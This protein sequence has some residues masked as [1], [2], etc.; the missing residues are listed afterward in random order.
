[1]DSLHRVKDYMLRIKAMNSF[2]GSLLWAHQKAS[3]CISQHALWHV[4]LWLRIVRVSSS[5]FC[6]VCLFFFRHYSDKNLHR[7]WMTKIN[8]SRTL[9]CQICNLKYVSKSP[10][11][12]LVF[13]SVCCWCWESSSFPHWTTDPQVDLAKPPGLL[14]PNTTGPK[15]EN[16][17]S[18][19]YAMCAESVT[20]LTYNKYNNLK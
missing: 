8:A 4:G 10:K 19:L 20:E 18:T 6:A 5:D 3:S 16:V 11:M 2:K 9:S 14:V 13:C 1:M 17:K 12:N 15:C 7:L